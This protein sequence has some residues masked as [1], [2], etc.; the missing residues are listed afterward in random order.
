MNAAEAHYGAELA[1]PALPG[2]DPVST[3]RESYVPGASVEDFK[4]K[5]RSLHASVIPN[6]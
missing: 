4:A 6:T 2:S 1:A 3:E 5:I